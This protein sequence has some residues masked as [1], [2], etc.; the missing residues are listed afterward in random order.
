MKRKKHN[1]NK[2]IIKL[3]R[4]ERREAEIKAHGKPIN[5]NR[6]SASPKAYK[7]VKWRN[8]DGIE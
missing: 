6:V 7:R 2:D 1:T 3:L 5:P 4:K 8:T